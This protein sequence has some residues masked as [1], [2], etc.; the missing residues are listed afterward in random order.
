MEWRCHG[1]QRGCP[2]LRSALVETAKRLDLAVR[3]GET[4]FSF[5]GCLVSVVT[6]VKVNAISNWQGP[7]GSRCPDDD[8]RVYLSNPFSRHPD[9]RS[10]C[11]TGL[12]KIR[13]LSLSQVTRRLDEHRFAQLK[14]TTDSLYNCSTLHAEDRHSPANHYPNTCR[15]AIYPFPTANTNSKHSRTYQ[16]TIG[17]VP[18]QTGAGTRRISR[19]EAKTQLSD[20]RHD[21]NRTAFP[22]YAIKLVLPSSQ[23]RIPASMSRHVA[24][25][26]VA[27]PGALQTAAIRPGA[28][29][30]GTTA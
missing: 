23:L 29:A 2:P 19:K 16:H 28:A 14:F 30:A 1:C 27:N 13:W 7:P 8:V 6:I 24:P 21:Q 3:L 20:H 4:I 15:V 25:R 17:H 5:F 18:K 11:F 9:V 22:R 26:S 10:W 12:P